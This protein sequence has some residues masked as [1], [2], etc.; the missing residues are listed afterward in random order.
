LSGNLDQ[1]LSHSL[2]EAKKEYKAMIQQIIGA[3]Q[4]GTGHSENAV[5]GYLATFLNSIGCTTLGGKR[6]TRQNIST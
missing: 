2:T 3:V 5:H 6:F 1:E 4:A